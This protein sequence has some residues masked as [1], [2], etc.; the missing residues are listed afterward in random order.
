M[1]VK[2]I[3]IKCRTFFFFFYVSLIIFIFFFFQKKRDSPEAPTPD[4]TT[5]ESKSYVCGEEVLV[6]LN[7]ERFYLG[8]IAKVNNYLYFNSNVKFLPNLYLFLVEV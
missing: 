4:S 6:H 8:F 7:D 2:L 5:V 1:H 3:S